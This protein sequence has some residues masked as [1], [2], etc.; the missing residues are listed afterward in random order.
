MFVIDWATSGW[1]PSFWEY[2][3]T[4][5]ACGGWRDDWPAYVPEMMEEFPSHFAWLN[6]FRHEIWFLNIL[7]SDAIA[8]IRD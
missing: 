7:P 6:K 1:Y 4:L 8:M 2:S 5:Y 3:T